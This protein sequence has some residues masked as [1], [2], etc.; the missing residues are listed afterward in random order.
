MTPV[1]AILCTAAIVALCTLGIVIIDA[2]RWGRSLK[3]MAETERDNRR[4][5]DLQ[6]NR[7]E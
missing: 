2:M 4:I 6:T 3:R 5:A 1:L 7:G